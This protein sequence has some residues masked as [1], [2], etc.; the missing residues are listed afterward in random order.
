MN[1]IKKKT[2]ISIFVILSVIVVISSIS[3]FFF[4]S[5]D[6]NLFEDSKKSN[7]VK[8]YVEKCLKTQTNMAQELIGSY[9][10]WLYGPKR[11]FTKKGHTESLNRN[12]Q[13]L[14]LFEEIELPY[15]VYFDDTQNKFKT[16]IPSFDGSGDQ[17]SIKSQME[18][19]LLENIENK[20]IRNFNIFKS[21]YA[22]SKENLTIDIET[23]EDIILHGATAVNTVNSYLLQVEQKL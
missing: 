12:M 23:S 9:G 17:Y 22:I 3:T 10:G 1:N 15:W 21:Q 2:Q 19:Y 4:F 5:D 18:K 11:S 7:N 16:Q 20:C 8:E 6:L 14:T 13:G